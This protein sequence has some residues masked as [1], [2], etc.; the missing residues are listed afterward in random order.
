MKA[1]VLR[2]GEV[3][4]HPDANINMFTIAEMKDK[5]PLSAN[6]KREHAFIVRK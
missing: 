5:H 2:H 4:Y 3:W 6:L 1:E